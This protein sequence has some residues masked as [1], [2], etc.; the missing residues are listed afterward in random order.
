MKFFKRI[1]LFLFALALVLCA[2]CAC[3]KTPDE[4]TPPDVQAN[5]IKLADLASYTIVVEKSTTDSVVNA[6]HKSLRNTL[7]EKLG[8]QFLPYQNDGNDAQA[9]EILI[10]HTNRAEST[11]FGDELRY[12]DYGYALINDKI[13]ILG[14]TESTMLSALALFEQ[15]LLNAAQDGAI[16]TEGQPRVVRATYATENATLGGLPVKG[17]KVV[18]PKENAHNEALYAENIAL[19]LRETAGYYVPCLADNALSANENGVLL[20]VGNVTL[21]GH[22]SAPTDL[23]ISEGC[24]LSDQNTI[25]LAG[26]GV[27]AIHEATQKLLQGIAQQITAELPLPTGRFTTSKD[28]VIRTMSFNVLGKAKDRN[29]TRDARV[30]AMINRY[31]PDTLGIQEGTVDW[32]N[33]LN[34]ALSD[35]YAWV[36][37]GNEGENKGEYSA[38]FYLK[39]KYTLIDSGTKWLSDTP[40]TVSKFDD[41]LCV[42]IATYAILERNSDG[43][44]FVHVNTHLDHGY[45]SVREAQV[46]V[47][48]ELIEQFNEYPMLITGDFNCAPSTAA[49]KTIVKAGYAS[50]SEVAEEAYITETYHGYQDLKGEQR[51]I[52]FCFVTPEKIS[53]LYYRVCNEKIN[54][55]YASDH[56]PIL[57]EFLIP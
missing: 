8:G 57:T 29:P 26:N 31:L 43:K 12:L 30:I 40:N 28:D 44:R 25:R 16:L 51:I 9:K 53:V 27:L 50:S 13:V 41:S 3:E 18:Y 2:F 24:I 47:L 36:G 1:G 55:D 4:P 5:T 56:H 34:A 42:R 33:T 32:M 21:N 15:D 17:M 49:I 52:D 20:I 10:G 19:A 22:M 11:V 45:D 39:D 7:K 23:S 54:G 37:V 6:S 38:I 46:E 48:L 35:R 14:H